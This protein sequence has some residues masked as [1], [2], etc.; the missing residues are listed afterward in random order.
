MWSPTQNLGLIGR[1]IMTCWIKTNR[2]AKYLD[3][4][5]PSLISTRDVILA[6]DVKLLYQV[7][8]KIFIEDWL[9]AWLNSIFVYTVQYTYIILPC[10]SNW[11]SWIFMYSIPSNIFWL[12][13][14]L[15]GWLVDWLIELFIYLQ[16]TQ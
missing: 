4:C 13:G 10:R 15:A 12:V 8:F 7:K 5:K 11:L 2:Q 1:A 9:V 3:R 16:Y 6:L 14:W